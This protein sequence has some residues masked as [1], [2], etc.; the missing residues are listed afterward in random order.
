MVVAGQGMTNQHGVAAGRV[1][2]A[3]GLIDH[4]KAVQHLA[5]LQREVIAGLEPLWDNDANAVP[6]CALIL[7][8]FKVD[9]P[10]RGAI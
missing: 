5:A 4:C 8:G 6:G 7:H 9:F 10:D 3:V 1:Q 2:G